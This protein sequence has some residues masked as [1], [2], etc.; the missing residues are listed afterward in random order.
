MRIEGNTVY[1]N[2]RTYKLDKLSKEQK[3]LMGIIKPKKEPEKVKSD[4]KV[5]SKKGE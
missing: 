5:E 1:F 3:I 2:K 4:K